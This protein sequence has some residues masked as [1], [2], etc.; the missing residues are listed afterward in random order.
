MFTKTQIQEVV[1][2]SYCWPDFDGMVDKLMELQECDVRQE[3]DNN[4]RVWTY[5]LEVLGTYK[6]S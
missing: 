4:R 1:S 2:K 6:E 3:P 5:K